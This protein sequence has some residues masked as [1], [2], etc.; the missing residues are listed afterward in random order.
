MEIRADLIKVK[1]TGCN[2]RGAKFVSIDSGLG[3]NIRFIY[4]IMGTFVQKDKN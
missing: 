3:T 1:L 4:I 2:R